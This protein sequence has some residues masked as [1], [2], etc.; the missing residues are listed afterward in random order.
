[1]AQYNYYSPGK[2]EN[3]SAK[4]QCRRKYFCNREVF[5]HRESVE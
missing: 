1:M 2:Y 5:Q 3:W 4:Q